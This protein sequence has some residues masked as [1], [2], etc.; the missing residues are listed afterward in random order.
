MIIDGANARHDDTANRIRPLLHEVNV[1]Q[2]LIPFSP[3]APHV[4]A[5]Q[6]LALVALEADRISL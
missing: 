3:V 1:D 2:R 4:D 5:A 6:N